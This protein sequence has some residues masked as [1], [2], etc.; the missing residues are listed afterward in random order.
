MLQLFTLVCVSFFIMIGEGNQT[1][2]KVT[3]AWIIVGSAVATLAAYTLYTSFEIFI[4]IYNW[5]KNTEFRENWALNRQED[6]IESH[7]SESATQTVKDPAE[8]APDQP[9]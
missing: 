2:G 6:E 5:A 4:M 1:S 7:H 9:N 8:K 3:L